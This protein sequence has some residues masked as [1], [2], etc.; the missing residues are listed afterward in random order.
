MVKRLLFS[1]LFLLFSA[2]L[3]FSQT[4]IRYQLGL[5]DIGLHELHVSAEFPN[6]PRQVL[7]VRMPRASPGRYAVHEFA[8]NV[9]DVRAY[10]EAGQELA[11]YRTTPH[12]WDVAG[13]DGYVRFDYTLYANHGDGTYS[14][15]DNR[16]LHLNMPA[17]FV[18]GVDMQDRPVELRIDL[19]G[20]PTWKVATQLVAT[21][22]DTYRAPD[23]Y[24]FYDSPVFV[25]DIDFRHWTSVSNGRYYTIELAM[26]HEGTDAELDDYAIWVQQVVEE[27]K[28]VFGELPDFDFG[29]YTF[30]CSYNPWVY[31]DGMEHR[32]S[33]ICSSRATLAENARRLI[34]TV[35][36]EFFHAWNVERIRPQSLEPFDFDEANMSEALWFAEG[37]TSYYT[38]LIL[39][40]AGIL[41]PEDYIRGLSGRLNYV[42]NAPGR[43]HRS[44]VE[45]SYNAPF[46]DAASSI[47]ETNFDNTFVSYYTY[48]SVLGLVLD[49]TLRAEYDTDLDTFMRR[50]WQEYGKT[51]V[52]YRLPDLERLLAEVSGDAAFAR[53]FF[54]ESIYGSELPD[55][56]ALLARFGVKT[57]LRRPGQP[58]LPR[59]LEY[60]PGGVLVDSPVLEG[61]PFHEAGIGQGDLLLEL[62]GQELDSPEALAAALEKMEIGRE[63]QVSFQ[64][65]G[66]PRASSFTLRQ[67]PSL[68]TLTGESPSEGAMKRRQAWLKTD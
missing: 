35:S 30:L 40:R 67:D 37:F 63:Y 10:D 60:T 12:Q 46:V 33:T 52:P 50:V 7:Q 18:Y 9:Y 25:G 57:Q 29:R 38:D 5:A 51:E 3:L 55:M 49:L 23:Y 28:A 2:A 14:G 32:N 41:A 44:P 17:T 22:E 1:L 6:L 15:V 68:E 42:L 34:G 27:Q 64:Q 13:H 8:K 43:R 58:Q 54:R 31:G 39:C 19:S 11:V 36:H 61:T 4:P 66:L 56:A 59:D 65:N 24:Y 20:R 48:G 16:K 45:M 26:L 62:A 21:E 53:R 47:D